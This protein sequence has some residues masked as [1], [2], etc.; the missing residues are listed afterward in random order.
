MENV[1]VDVMMVVVTTFSSS[2]V[3]GPVE[4]DITYIKS[5]VVSAV[6]SSLSD[7]QKTVESLVWGFA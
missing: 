5:V 7:P 1:S 6:L 4:L 3:D 2:W